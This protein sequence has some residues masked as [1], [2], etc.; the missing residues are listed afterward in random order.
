MKIREAILNCDDT[1][2]LTPVAIPE[3]GYETGVFIKVMS[4]SQR[5]EYEDASI[6]TGTDGKATVSRKNFRARLL[7]NTL[8]DEN[9]DLIFA[10]SDIPKLG[11][12]SSI[13]VDRL[14]D[15]ALK[16]N[17]IT[18]EAQAETEKN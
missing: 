16:V 9:G 7:V 2:D 12:K 17:K 1:P 5:D 11:S 18:E 14:V 3:W 15:V 8:C 6:T 13:V 10:K 4:G